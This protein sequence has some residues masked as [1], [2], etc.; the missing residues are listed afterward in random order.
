MEIADDGLRK[1]NIGCNDLFYRAIIQVLL[2]IDPQGRQDQPFLIKLGRIRVRP[3]NRTAKL[4]MVADAASK[5]GE[6]AFVEDRHDEDNVVQMLAVL[7]GVVG[8]ESVG[9]PQGREVVFRLDEGHRGS[10]RVHMNGN[11]LRL[12]HR[13]GVCIHDTG[14]AVLRLTH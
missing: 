8:N 12:R 1:A 2:H 9:W 4:Q 6:F 3:G 11:C 14:R 13:L 10:E 7:I 5:G